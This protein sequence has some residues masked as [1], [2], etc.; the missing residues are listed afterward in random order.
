MAQES[1]S[2]SVGIVKPSDYLFEE[3][4]PLDCGRRLKNVVIR[5][6]TYGKLSPNA[7]NAVLVEHALSGDAHLAGVYSPEDKKPGWWDDMV[8]PGKQIGRASCRERV[9][10]TV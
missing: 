8:G 5:Y 9:L 6:E 4:L 2:S 1:C 7:D 10:P 3:E